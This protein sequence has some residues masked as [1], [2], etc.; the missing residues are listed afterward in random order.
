MFD[1]NK[2]PFVIKLALLPVLRIVFDD[3]ILVLLL[4][5]LNKA[6]VLGGKAGHGSILYVVKRRRR[7]AGKPL[8]L[9]DFVLNLFRAL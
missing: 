4:L 2:V 6:D 3:N 8:H 7:C 9:G 1:G 5:W